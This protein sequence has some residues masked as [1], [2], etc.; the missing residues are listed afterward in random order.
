MSTFGC[1]SCK[2]HQNLD[3]YK[4]KPWEELPCATCA[5]GK[6]YTRTWNTGFFDTGKEDSEVDAVE[7]EFKFDNEHEFVT[8]G[9]FPL[10]EEETET[11]ERIKKAVA[12]QVCK[13]FAGL[14]V[15][16]LHMAKT[17][18]VLFEVI[19]KKMQYPH[20][21]YSALGA[22]MVPKC[23]KQNVLYHLKSA[24]NVFPELEAVIP[25]D[26]RY[27]SGHYALRTLAERRMAE[28]AEKR[29][30]ENLY[31]RH[32]VKTMDIE[33]LNSILH[34]PVLVRDEVFTFNAYLQDEEKLNDAAA[35]AD[36]AETGRGMPEDS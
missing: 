20:M 4:D 1:H 28:E 7:G 2:V 8:T 14:L 36:E 29:L 21:S 31:G 19:I 18:P 34:S 12:Q 33:E 6:N 24:I 9:K 11:L 35:D 27:T 15:R 5:M 16:M 22:T 10:T 17:N 23:S 26:T 25:T 32:A 30:R 13:T 3:Q